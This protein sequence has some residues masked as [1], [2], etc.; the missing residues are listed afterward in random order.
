MRFVSVIIVAASVAQAG[1]PKPCCCADRR[2]EAANET[3]PACPLCAA[4]TPG[5]APRRDRSSPCENCPRNGCPCKVAP[6]D[7]RRVTIAPGVRFADALYLCVESP[8][9]FKT[10]AV[11]TREA[12][13]QRPLARSGPP[14]HVLY[15]VF[16]C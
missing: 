10:A 16:L 2:A 14:T 8:A 3:K 13:P 4:T 6:I 7:H 1:F 5:P 9:V 15:S 11:P 12:S